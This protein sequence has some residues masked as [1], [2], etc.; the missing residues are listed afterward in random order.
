MRLL[1]F[2]TKGKSGQLAVIRKSGCLFFL[3][4]CKRNIASLYDAGPVADDQLERVGR[5]LN[6]K[7]LTDESEVLLSEHDSVSRKR[8]E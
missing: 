5:L 3:Y 7:D 8:D 1:C 4:L 2:I 6:E